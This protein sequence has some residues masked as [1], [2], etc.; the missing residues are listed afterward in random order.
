MAIHEQFGKILIHNSALP[1]DRNPI[2]AICEGDAFTA[3][4]GPFSRAGVYFYYFTLHHY[5]D[6]FYYGAPGDRISS[7]G[8]RSSTIPAAF[9]I[10]VCR[11]DFTAPAWFRKSVMYQIFPDRYAKG[12]QEKIRLF[13]NA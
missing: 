5:G 12:A 10:T 9:Q 6:T 1:A 11:R 3:S 13:Q 4:V 8:E 2:G 7:V